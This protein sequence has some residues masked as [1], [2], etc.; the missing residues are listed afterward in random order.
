ML[1]KEKNLKQQPEKI[2]NFL[3]FIDNV[4]PFY[5]L[6]YKDMLFIKRNHNFMP[7][8]LFP[9]IEDLE[10]KLKEAKKSYSLSNY[11]YKQTYSNSCA[12]AC[13]MMASSNYLNKQSFPSKKIETDILNKF[14]NDVSITKVLDL[15]LSEK[16][17]VKV[18]SEL[19]HREIKFE[20]E[21]AETLRKDFVSFYKKHYKNP[22]IQFSFNR[23]LEKSTLKDLLMNGES[24]LING[25]ISEIP[26]MRV[27]TGYDEENFVV[28]DP[29]EY[30]K[31]KVTFSI[32]NE[33]SKPPLG[34]FFFS[35]TSKKID[36]E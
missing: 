35:L 13:Y 17:N 25:L 10:K 31:S 33:Q 23:N 7:K 15:C 26:H 19:D 4:S 14:N 18:F 11:H 28:S 27:V 9:K 24:V 12:I 16:L 34:Q 32:L 22:Q 8:S 5:K 30:R 20:E 29:I 2:K 6:S 21:W 3:F 1:E 36:G